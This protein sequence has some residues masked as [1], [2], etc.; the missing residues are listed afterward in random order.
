MFTDQQWALVFIGF[1]DVMLFVCVCVRK[2][3]WGSG[4]CEPFTCVQLEN[5]ICM[6]YSRLE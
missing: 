4:K 6:S 2:K 3:L 5:N 1:V